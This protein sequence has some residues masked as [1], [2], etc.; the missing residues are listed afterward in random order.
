M[1]DIEVFKAFAGSL[2]SETIV[3][4]PKEPNK[5][6]NSLK[7]GVVALLK[8]VVPRNYKFLQ[9]WHVLA[10]YAFDYWEPDLKDGVVKN[11]D[12]F[13]DWIKVQSGYYEYHA[14][15]NGKLRTVAKSVSFA[16]M[17]EEDFADF[18]KKASD[19]IWTYI[20]KN[21]TKEDKERVLYELNGFS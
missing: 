14:L 21:Y 19:V 10:D 11:I 5:W 17:T 13:K 7:M 8:I 12:T 15:P 4:V 2:P 6:L 3:I 18:Y 16:S 9:K 1:P 20:V